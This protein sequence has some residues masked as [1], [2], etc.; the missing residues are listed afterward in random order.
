MMNYR[1]DIFFMKCSYTIL[2]ILFYLMIKILF[3]LSQIIYFN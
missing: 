1:K 3:L 2:K